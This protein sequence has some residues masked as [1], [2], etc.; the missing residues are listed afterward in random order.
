LGVILEHAGFDGTVAVQSQFALVWIEN[1][2]TLIPVIFIVIACVALYKYPI[3]KKYYEEM[4][5]GQ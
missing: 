2:A 4:M 3:T 5:K 1:A